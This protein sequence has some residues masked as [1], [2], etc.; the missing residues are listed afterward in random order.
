MKKFVVALFVVVPAVAMAMADSTPPVYG[1]PT[2]YGEYEMDSARMSRA[3]KFY[4]DAPRI[5][6]IPAKNAAPAAK[7]PVKAKPAVPKQVKKKKAAKKKVTQPK[8]AAARS[9]D[10]VQVSVSAMHIEKTES[11][12]VQPAKKIYM[13]APSAVAIAGAAKQGREFRDVDSF[14]TRRAAPSRKSS[15][16]GIVLMPGRPDL[17]SCGVK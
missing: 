12:S 3:A 14:C 2:L 6:A 4:G 15:M 7:R 8:A 17:M 13:P 5:A 11:V 16:P 1:R 10:E 9:A